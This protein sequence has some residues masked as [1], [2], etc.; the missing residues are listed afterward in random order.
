MAPSFPKALSR[1]EILAETLGVTGRHQ[2]TELGQPCFRRGERIGDRLAVMQQDV[3]PHLRL[4][5]GETSG[6]AGAGA[7]GHPGE[8]PVGHPHV[9][10]CYATPRAPQGR[11]RETE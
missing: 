5:G 3:D 8:P 10:P 1:E 4:T 2:A 9:R 11:Q 7:E 6:V